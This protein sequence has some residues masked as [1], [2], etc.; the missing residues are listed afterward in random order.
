MLSQKKI[1]EALGANL[2]WWQDRLF[3]IAWRLGRKSVVRAVTDPLAGECFPRAVIHQDRRGTIP[4]LG[5]CP[6]AKAAIDY[7]CCGAAFG[8]GE[9]LVAASQSG[10]ASRCTARW[11]RY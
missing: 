8:E 9:S 11:R 3:G 1:V 10:C 4:A 5:H 2:P 6:F 7:R